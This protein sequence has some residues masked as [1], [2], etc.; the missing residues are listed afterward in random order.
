MLARQAAQSS[1]D[2]AGIGSDPQERSGQFNADSRASTM[3]LIDLDLSFAPSHYLDDDT[4]PSTSHS[5]MDSIAGSDVAGANP[6]NLEKNA[7][8]SSTCTSPGSQ[9][10][11]DA[12]SSPSLAT[13][14]KVW[15]S[16]QVLKQEHQNAH[17]Q[18]AMT[19]RPYS[20]SDFADT[21]PDGD[22]PTKRKYI[23]GD[24]DMAA[25]HRADYASV[26]YTE[27]FLKELRLPHLPA[28]PAPAILQG[29]ATQE[30]IKDELRRLTMSFGE[31]LRVTND[32]LSSKQRP[33]L[34]H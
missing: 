24:L 1:A 26:P 20:L 29:Y 30:D 14:E 5:G 12:A 21:E 3:S 34:M 11:H 23:D 13:P 32:C 6:F 31:H 28:A 10:G 15:D 8:L 22:L 33:A 25:Q 16:E 18:S 7:S 27:E 4:R 17:Q 9:P 19:G 2:V